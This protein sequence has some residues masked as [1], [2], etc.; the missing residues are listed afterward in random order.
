[1]RM[2][3]KNIQPFFIFGSPRSG[4]SL[5]SR[6]LDS[7]ENLTVANESLIFKMFASSLSDYGDLTDIQNQK[8]LLKDI[9]ATRIICYWS[10][11]PE[12][13]K[14]AP[15]IKQPG[16]AGVI[17]ALICSRAPEKILLAWGEK[18]PGHIFY[19]KEIKQTFPNAK[20]VHIVRDGR[21]VAT[22]IINAR[23]GPKTYFA[24]AK[25]WC[26]CLDGIKRIKQ[27]CSENNFIEIRY[28]DLLSAPKET[29][30]KVCSILGVKYSEDMLKF[31]KSKASYQTDSINLKNLNKPL[32]S[33]NKEKWRKILTDQNLQEFETVAGEHLTLY[34][35]EVANKMGL[36]SAYKM[37]IIQYI[38]SPSIR[39]ISRAKDTQGQKAFL[40]LKKVQLMRKILNVFSSTN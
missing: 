15:L 7:H 8:K 14:I 13:D 30:Q 6:M 31:F 18:S 23:M 33:S 39:F 11:L 40:N 38:L 5:L 12:F 21:D 20:V 10:P 32:I 17:E 22:S 4:T 28:E 25:M 37:N 24:A 35:Y 19:W 29:L 36:L 26:D 1:M 27:D 34:G 9:L 2:N 3:E 16:F